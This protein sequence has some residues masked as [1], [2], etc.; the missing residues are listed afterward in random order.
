[1]RTLVLAA[2]ALVLAAPAHAQDCADP[3]DFSW[4][5]RSFETDYGIRVDGSIDAVDRIVVDFGDLKR[6]GIYRVIPVDR[7]EVDRVVDEAGE[8]Y[9]VE[10]TMTGWLQRIRIG[11][12]DVCVTG[13]NTYVIH[14]EMPTDQAVEHGVDGDELYW[15]VT[16]TG[17]PVPIERAS[18]TVRLPSD[19]ANAF[20]DSTPWTARCFAGPPASSSTTGCAAAVLEPGRYEFATTAPL[21][22]GEGLT[23]RASFSDGLVREAGEAMP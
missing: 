4:T 11:S 5:I 7:L 2:S 19:R 23:I 15:Q 12:P 16:G 3:D 9:R 10:V 14:Y 13:E 1:M 20:A 18:A 8:A 21:N 6:H 22:K 17:W